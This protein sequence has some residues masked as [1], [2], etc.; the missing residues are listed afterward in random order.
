MRK[1]TSPQPTT[2]NRGRGA[3]EHG[4][5]ARTKAR[6][7]QAEEVPT[8]AP[9]RPADGEV[10]RDGAVEAGTLGTGKELDRGV[11]DEVGDDVGNKVGEGGDRG[12]I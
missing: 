10:G 2:S 12:C 3:G 6:V 11:G 9:G 5:A 1:P 8:A 4:R 7:E